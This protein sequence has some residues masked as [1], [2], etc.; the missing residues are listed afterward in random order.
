M[1]KLPRLKPKEAMR[2]L[3]RAGFV[4]ERTKGSHSIF[5][6]GKHRV[7]VAF[8]NKDMRHKTVRSMIE[9][10]GLTVEEFRKLL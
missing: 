1:P 2:A 4:L 10:T 7:T 3:E 9:Q 8:H 5:I 6:K